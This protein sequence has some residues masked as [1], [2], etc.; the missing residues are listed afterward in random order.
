MRR[1]SIARFV[2]FC[3]TAVMTTL[4]FAASAETALQMAN[5]ASQNFR[6]AKSLKI[7]YTVSGAYGSG[8]GSFEAYN[9][10]FAFV[11]PRGGV[12]YDGSSMWTY[13][14]RTGEATVVKPSREE[15]AESNPFTVLGSMS[16]AFNA[17][18]AKTSPSGTKVIVLTRKTT[19]NPIKKIVLTLDASKL[20]PRKMVITDDSGTSTISVTKYTVGG[21]SSAVTNY[22]FPSRK[23]PK[24]KTV[25]LR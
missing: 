18:F 15:L 23:Y 21:A 4:T 3:L 5:R 2:A 20:T 16:T 14:G 6:S 22:R 25:D 7:T 11:H 9:G 24:A 8:S 1:L 12:W 13:S 17:A 19:R 10:R